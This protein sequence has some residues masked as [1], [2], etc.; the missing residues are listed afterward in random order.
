VRLVT[1]SRDIRIEDFTNALELETER[2]D[3][4][5]HAERVPVGKI[6]AHSRSGNIDLELPAKARFEL[7][8]STSRG[9]A[10][11]DFGPAI[12][13]VTDGRS[14]S[15]HGTVGQGPS[16]VLS[17]DRGSVTVRKSGDGADAPVVAPAAPPVPPAPPKANI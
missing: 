8:A 13:L 17:T 9:E 12:Q 2:G 3:I 14:A 4:E 5:L 6:E 1:R 10:R 11:N 7:K 16:I 15:L